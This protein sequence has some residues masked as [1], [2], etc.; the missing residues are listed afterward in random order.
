MK[1][2]LKH[3]RL[4]KEAS[5]YNCL[6][7]EDREMEIDPIFSRNG[8]PIVQVVYYTDYLNLVNEFISDKGP[9]TRLSKDRE[10]FEYWDKN[11]DGPIKEVSFMTM[12][13]TILGSLI[14]LM[15]NFVRVRKKKILELI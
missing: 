7:G 1:E 3:A 13:K 14:V 2:V 8:H 15:F 9:I 6:W 11:I 10:I 5:R 4:F 12:R